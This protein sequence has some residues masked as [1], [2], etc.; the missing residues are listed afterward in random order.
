MSAKRNAGAPSRTEKL[1]SL[2]YALMSRR[3]GYTRAELRGIVDDY[4][5]LSDDAFERKFERD[6]EDLRA[7]GI[8]LETLVG[9]AYYGNDRQ[10]THYRVRPEEYRL[11]PVSFAPEE[12]MALGL[13][14][15][16]W[17][18][19][20]IASAA[21]R[22]FH[23][24]SPAAAADPDAAGAAF[25]TF[26]PRLHAADAVFRDLLGAVWD[27]SPIRFTY[28]S[29]SGE[30]AV[31]TLEP[32]GIGNR[33]G[34][35]YLVGWDRDRDG[36][37]IFRLSRIVSEIA[38][39][40]GTVQRP[41]GF[42]VGDVL[43][44]LDPDAARQRATVRLAP[45]RGLALRARADADASDAEAGTFSF[46]YQDDEATSA[47][48]AELGPAVAVAGPGPLRAAVVRRLTGALETH[49]G[50]TPEYAF[51]QS[52]PGG[53]PSTSDVV[54]RALDIIA[55][56]VREGAPLINETAAHFGLS[57][58]RLIEDLTM[59][60]LCGVPNG[61]PD[62]LIDVDFEGDR[63]S[64]AN[65]EGLAAPIRLNL[66]EAFS[67]L[68]GLQTILDLPGTEDRA[69]ARGALEKLRSVAGEFADLDRV[70][71]AR[72]AAT[73]ASGTR[74]TVT[75]AIAGT[76]VLHLRYYHPGRDEISERDVE[77][78]RL[79]E[80]GGRTYL[81]AWC[82]TATGQ[83]NFRL[84]RILAATTSGEGFTRVPA[85]HTPAEGALYTPATEDTV[86]VLGFAPRIQRLATEF[87][88]WQSTKTKD[89]TLIAQVGIAEAAQLPGL[90]ARHGGELRVIDPPE[91]ADAVRRWLHGALAADR[92]QQPH[93]STK[94]NA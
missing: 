35:W 56:V 32:W 81:Q 15:R 34:H 62:E 75:A 76:Q 73:E 22:A 71:S 43:D 61:L 8:P 20:T 86:V 17:K 31:R 87:A 83:R 94:E 72:L 59:I 4:Q 2:T 19:P 45:G 25:E 39:R 26:E 70:A 30:A 23:R 41:E 12:A 27:R 91:A 80:D 21:D 54:A 7:L 37:R 63:V 77:P 36:Q 64:I 11:P 6:K 74:D 78:I 65:A 51:G 16:V 47:E 5:G 14:A 92:E 9:D 90:V 57:R 46:D 48:L 53:R 3:R 82:R 24:I 93:S 67:L 18:D 52:R 28:R 33:F 89:G 29:P 40:P 49:Q 10:D 79:L 44:G 55:Y 84:D 69:A 1:V 42:R 13:A 66:V 58:R 68:V 50:P 85:R 88:P 60:Q 38:R